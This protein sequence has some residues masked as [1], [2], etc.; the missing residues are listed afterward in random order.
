M[1][2]YYPSKVVLLDQAESDLYDLNQEL[3][4][5]NNLINWEVVIGDVTRKERMERLFDHFKPN[6]IF[7]AAAYKHVPLMELNP[8]ESIRTNVHGTKIMADLCLSLM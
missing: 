1:V 7:H 4:A 6:I 2:K 3:I 5:E 8:A